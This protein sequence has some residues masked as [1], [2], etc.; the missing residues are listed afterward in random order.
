MAG[1][2]WRADA[3]TRAA[4]IVALGDLGD[5]AALPVLEPLAAAYAD[6]RER[7]FDLEGSLAASAVWQMRRRNGG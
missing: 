1:D 7:R 5:P 6:E 3:E 4:A 2:A